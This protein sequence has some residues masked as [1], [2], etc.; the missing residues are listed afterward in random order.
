VKPTRTLQINQLL[1]K[2]CNSNEIVFAIYLHVVST[3]LSY[4]IQYAYRQFINDS[5]SSLYLL[6]TYKFLSRVSTFCYMFV[7]ITQSSVIMYLI[8]L[9][10]FYSINMYLHCI[11][12]CTTD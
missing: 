3:K 10:S 4:V 1:E 7:V 8:C 2:L 9:L 6:C 12:A 11:T 5:C